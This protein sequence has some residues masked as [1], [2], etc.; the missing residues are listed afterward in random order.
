M[1]TVSHVSMTLHLWK[2]PR[3]TDPDEA[4][5]LIELDDESVFEP[6]ED[7]R[8]FY[9]ELLE[10]FPPPEALTEEQLEDGSSPW[11]DTLE[12]TDRL[13]FL[14]VRWSA[15]DEHLDTIVE[16][17]RRYDLVLYDPQGPSFHSPP[18]EHEGEPYVPTAGDYVRGFLM[19]A[20]GL[21]L[22]FVAWK[23]SITVLSWIVIF[24]GCFI[25]L[26]AIVGFVTTVQQSL[27]ARATRKQ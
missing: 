2:A 27:R 23:A 3:V 18:D 25:A 11:A 8:R 10:I 20:F 15:N 9:A 19:A 12:G 6:S 5:R 1:G 7:L 22:A 24:V 16:L 17:A 13:V 26:I 14:S 21:A 4:Q